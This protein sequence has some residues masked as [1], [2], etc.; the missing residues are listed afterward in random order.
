VN[1]G[2]LRRPRSGRHRRPHRR[3]AREA[4]SDRHGRHL[5]EVP[6]LGRSGSGTAGRFHWHAG[7]S[8]SLPLAPHLSRYGTKGPGALSAAGRG[9]LSIA[10]GERAEISPRLRQSRSTLAALLQAHAQTSNRSLRTGDRQTGWNERPKFDKLE[11]QLTK[12]HIRYQCALLR[13]ARPARTSPRGDQGDFAAVGWLPESRLLILPPSLPK[14]PAQPSN[15]ARTRRRP[16]NSRRDYSVT[17]SAKLPSMR[18]YSARR[19]A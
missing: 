6:R 12:E 9:P 7:Q 4:R 5:A 3:L 16:M 11:W 15:G 1:C 17:A 2:D 13:T 8:R 19:A 14:A 18:N 10:P